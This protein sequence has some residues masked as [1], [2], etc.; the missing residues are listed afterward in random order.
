MTSIPTNIV[1]DAEEAP[2][3]ISGRAVLE[4]AILLL[5]LMLSARALLQT[6]T[7]SDR[8]MTPTIAEK[9]TLVISRLTFQLRPPQRGELVL[10]NESG[11]LERKIV[12]RVIG[13]PGDV[14][15][16]RGERTG[17]EGVQIAVNG[18][19]LIE[20]YVAA[21]LQ[22]STVVSVTARIELNSDEFYVMNDNRAVP[23]DSRIWGP[24]HRENL[25]G[26]AWL[27]VLP[28]DELRVIDHNAVR[29]AGE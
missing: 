17:I 9:Q 3:L 12:R 29:I 24:I 11:A 25:A 14:I 15:E 16:L 8:A 10:V 20:P 5:I 18:R 22:N 21:Q 28:L 13:L 23:G 19:P 26:R 1:P 7:V 6:Y 2:V 4:V 27:A